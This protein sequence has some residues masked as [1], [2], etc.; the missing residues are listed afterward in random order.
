ML[1]NIK[2]IRRFDLA[3]IIVMIS[4]KV[5]VTCQTLA[6]RVPS[7]RFVLKAIIT[8]L[9]SKSSQSLIMK[10]PNRVHPIHDFQPDSS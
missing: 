8:A 10:T 6:K 7:S 9:I 1:S 3:S 4:I 5:Y 2:K